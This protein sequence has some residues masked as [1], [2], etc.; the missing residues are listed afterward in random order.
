MATRIKRNELIMAMSGE[1]AEF[2]KGKESLTYRECIDCIQAST[3]RRLKERP[4][5]KT[6]IISCGREFATAFLQNVK[7]VGRL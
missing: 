5:E 6:F 4:Q 1:L 7:E 2:I 3:D